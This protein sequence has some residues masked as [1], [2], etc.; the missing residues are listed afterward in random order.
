MQV[1]YCYPILSYFKHDTHDTSTMGLVYNRYIEGINNGLVLL[2]FLSYAGIHVN[3]TKHLQLGP[4]V[5]CL[6]VV[7]NVKSGTLNKIANC[8]SKQ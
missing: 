3:N 7:S 1:A 2:L 6:Q 4:F 8:S 5:V